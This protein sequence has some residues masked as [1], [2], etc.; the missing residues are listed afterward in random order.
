MN[1]LIEI[2]RGMADMLDGPQNAGNLV[3]PSI[4]NRLRDASNAIERLEAENTA[5]RTQREQPNEPLTLDELRHM[6]REPVWLYTFSSVRKKTNI[7][8][9]VILEAVNSAY[10]VFVR[11]GCNSRLTKRFSNYGETW[12]AYRRKPRQEE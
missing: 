6:D 11:A 12:L 1:E 9:W 4:I 8:Q 5:L 10:A 3:V 7:S 2:L